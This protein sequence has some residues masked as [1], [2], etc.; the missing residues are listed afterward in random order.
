MGEP[1]WAGWRFAGTDVWVRPGEVRVVEEVRTISA[2]RTDTGIAIGTAVYA[3]AHG[4]PRV[5]VG[6]EG[7]S[8]TLTESSRLAADRADEAV[9]DLA[10]VRS[11]MPGT[12]IALSVAPGQ[13]V[14]AGDPVVTVEAMKMEHTLRA[15]IA[16]T[17]AEVLVAVGDRVAL[18]EDLVRWAADHD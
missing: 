3:V 17:V 10:P 5:W 6:R 1:A 13:S 7:R 8:W 2:A 11:P 16:A 9:G 14:A 15:P 12:V 18:D 4:G